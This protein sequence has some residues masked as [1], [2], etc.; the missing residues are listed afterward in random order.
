MP[1]TAAEENTWYS[2]YQTFDESHN[3]EARR[4]WYSEA[5]RA[6]SW[7]R[8]R[9]PDDLVEQVIS[10]LQLQQSLAASSVLGSILEIGCGPGIATVAFASKGFRIQAIEPSAAACKLA[11]LSCQEYGDRITIHNHTFENYS[12]NNQQFDAVLAATSFHWLSP[13]IACKKS[14]AALKP[15]GSLILLWATPPQPGADLCQYL[16]P[17]YER[18]GLDDLGREQQRDRAYYQGNFEMFAKTVGNSGHFQPSP[19]EIE[20]HHSIYSIEKYLALL[21]TLSGYIALETQRR[22][23]LLTELGDRLAEKL[24]TG[25]LETTHYFASQV[26]SLIAK[27]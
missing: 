26:A 27:A 2:W 8:P 15:G 6:Y 5:A 24:E 13:E 12:L 25:A 3:P 10:Q 4:Q 11:Q 16:Q 9:Y 19:V 17:V 22:E 18:Y 1:T 14:A 20:T 7:A 23:E 21:S